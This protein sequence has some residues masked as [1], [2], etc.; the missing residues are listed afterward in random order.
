M[1]D[2]EKQKAHR[3]WMEWGTNK[4]IEILKDDIDVCKKI[5]ATF[6]INVYAMKCLYSAHIVMQLLLTIFINKY[7]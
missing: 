1:F 6:N 3:Y 2:E 5:P 7:I 4:A